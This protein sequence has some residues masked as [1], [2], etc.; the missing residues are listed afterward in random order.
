M[1]IVNVASKCGFTSQY[2]GLQELFE[3]YCDQGLSI[4][5]FPSNDFGAQE[6]GSDEQINSFCQSNYQVTFDLFSKVSVLGYKKLPLYQ[7]L[8]NCG[9]EPKGVGGLRSCLFGFVKWLLYRKKG[10][11]IPGK[12]EAQW[13]FHK[14]LVDKNGIP[15]ASFLSEVSP[16][17]PI[18]IQKLEEELQKYGQPLSTKRKEYSG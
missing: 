16:G 1:L 2:P 18:L 6:P 17:S 5:A 15:V 14:F 12:Y 10:M 9:L 4:L 8:Y 11:L 13:N 3:K 7:Y